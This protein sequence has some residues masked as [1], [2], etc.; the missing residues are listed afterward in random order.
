MGAKI[1]QI[2]KFLQGA[3]KFIKSFALLL[4]SEMKLPSV[5]NYVTLIPLMRL[6]GI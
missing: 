1:A 5:Q 2:S 6:R 3:E 4:T